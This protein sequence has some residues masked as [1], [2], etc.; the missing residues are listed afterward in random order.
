VTTS[1]TSITSFRSEG[2]TVRPSFVPHG[3]TSP[4][5]L[6][7]DEQGLTQLTGTPGVAWQTPWV[8]LANVQLVRFSRGLALFATADGVR[9]CWRTPNKDDY[10]VLATVIGQHGGRVVRRRRRAGIYA[11]VLVVLLASAAGA[12]GAY[13]DRGSASATIIAN[14]K[15]VNLSVRDLPSGWSATSGSILSDLFG[16]PGRVITSTTSTTQPAK[17][18][19]WAKVSALF[20]HCVG[21]SAQKDR[22]YGA[23]GQEPDYQVSSSVFGSSSGVNA[24]VASTTQ[25][26]HTTTMV[27]KDTA[28]MRDPNF[29]A[30]FAQTNAALLQSV[31]SSS[32]AGV[33][34]GTN[35]RPVT[36]VKGFSRG[37]VEKILVPGATGSVYLVMVQITA[38]HYEVT[39]G[40]LLGSWTQEKPFVANLVNTLL[41]RMTSTSSAA[42]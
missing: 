19:T 22:M 29:G 23:A 25:Y 35:W 15:A 38:G 30:C 16:T 34:K 24:E 7:G 8:E 31:Y 13:F 6:L 21:V 27:K 18:S 11:V 14:T 37:G 40:A 42:V 12:I 2:W 28:E 26:Y 4:V 1:S 33:A 3:P 5:T 39:L 32:F 36:F 9:Y 20:Q 41:S 10:E 17:D